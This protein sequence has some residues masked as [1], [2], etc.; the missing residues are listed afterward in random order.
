MTTARA[1]RYRTLA[2]AEPDADAAQL[3]R[4]IADEADRGFLCVAEKHSEAGPT[5]VPIAEQPKP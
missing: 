3:F 4:L 2:L 5:E 1:L